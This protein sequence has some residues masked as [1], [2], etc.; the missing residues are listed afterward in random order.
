MPWALVLLA[1][2]GGALVLSRKRYRFRVGSQ[3]RKPSIRTV[4]RPLE[5]PAIEDR[6]SPVTR[7][8]LQVFQGGLISEASV[9]A[10]KADLARLLERGDLAAAESALRPGLDYLVQIRALTEIGTPT[11]GQLLERQLDRALSEDPLEQSCYAVDLARG[12]R[13][14]QRGESLPTLLRK[15]DR[16]LAL[17]LGALYAGELVAFAGF[18][19][20]LTSRDRVLKRSAQHVLHRAMEGIRLGEL[21]LAVFA[22]AQ[23]GEI[24]ARLASRPGAAKDPGILRIFVEGLRHLRRSENAERFVRGDLSLQDLLHWQYACLAE[25]EAALRDA[26]I[27]AARDLPSVILDS[28]DED[29]IDQLA[30]V[31]VLK[32]DLGSALLGLLTARRTAVREDVLRGLRWSHDPQIVPTLCGA[33]R[34]GANPEQAEAILFALR[35]HPCDG[36]ER[37]LLRHTLSP[38]PRLRE[39]AIRSLGWWEPIYRVEVMAALNRE[40]R[41]ASRRIALFAEAAL[42][43]LGDRAAL[44]RWRVRLIG[45]YPDRVRETIRLTAEEGLNWLWPDLDRLVDAEDLDIAFDACEALEQLR[46]AALGPLA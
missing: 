44:E 46:E 43:R 20:C 37:E 23:L 15:A 9:E 8:H 11:A 29:L 3:G 28:T 19:D 36:A 39:A 30:I 35:Q 27:L 24:I 5:H 12:L 16:A 6:Y 7:Q 4:P 13:E 14:L 34:H 18:T 26:L 41:Q 32:L 2:L 45:E 22:E 42:A 25:S 21:S 10:K 38:D 17:P 33:L 1:V 40:S 31:D